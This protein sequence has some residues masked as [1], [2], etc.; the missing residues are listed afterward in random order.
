MTCNPL[1]DPADQRVPRIPPPCALTIFGVTGDLAR[2]KVLPAIYDLANR[3]LLPAGFSLTGV[4]RSPWTTQQFINQAHAAVTSGART[5]FRQRV[6]EQLTA[7]MAYVSGDIADPST[8]AELRQALERSDRDFGTGANRAFYLSMP[9]STFAPI[10]GHLA[11]SGL[12]QDSTA[13]KVVIEKP[14][15]HDLASARALDATLAQVFDPSAIFRIDH[16][17]GKETVR[18]MLATRFANQVF[19]PLWS[20]EYVDHVQ[21]TMAEE[22]GVGSRASYY[23][24]I[25]ATRDVMQ[26]HLLQ[27]LAITAMEGPGSFG[28]ADLRRAKENALAAVRLAG[29]ANDCAVRGQYTA[30][31]QGNIAVPGYLD[32]PG[33]P[34]GSTTDT[35]GALK[36]E[37]ATDRWQGTPFYLRTG[38]RLGRR[39]TEVAIQF[40]RTADQVRAGLETRYMGANA[41]VIRIQP[42]EGIT[43]RVGA[44]V[45]QTDME[46]R[47][48]TMDFSYGHAFT[49]SLPDA[50]ERLILDVLLSYDPLF[51]G[52]REVDE[53]WRVIDPVE[54]HW[55]SLG[56]PPDPYAA[57]TW[58]PAA[59]DG[60]LRRDGREWRRP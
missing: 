15:G 12:A 11:S 30:G 29:Q 52:A 13:A 56:G 41:L 18:G 27:L 43:L 23:D 5:P 28:A 35:F 20:H 6:W 3:G 36:L 48:V 4:A 57:G 9:P 39:V 50:Y 38:K 25:G 8:Y 16:Y 10:C 24:Q 46:V 54:Q 1:V 44:K 37:I 31:W 21:I 22:M 40:S 51:P 53:S 42:D 33:I 7:S 47:D 26:N 2:R 17:L 32:E 45:P 49:E 60:L 34:G 19:E 55:A 58:G 59:A 14:F